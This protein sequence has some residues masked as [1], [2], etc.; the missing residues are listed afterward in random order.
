MGKRFLRFNRIYLSSFQLLLR[1]IRGLEVFFVFC[2]FWKG[3]RKNSKKENAKLGFYRLFGLEMM[4]RVIP[5][6][7]REKHL[8]LLLRTVSNINF[9]TIILNIT[10]FR[11]LICRYSDPNSKIL[12][13]PTAHPCSRSHE[14]NFDHSHKFL[15]ACIHSFLCKKFSFLLTSVPST[16]YIN[17]CHF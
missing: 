13:V 1:E 6:H 7:S 17:G 12:P 10:S 16:V 3:G 5:L 8:S 15:S 11:M 2:F 14:A 4:R 9:N